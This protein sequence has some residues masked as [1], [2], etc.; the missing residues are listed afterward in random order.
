MRPP[1]DLIKGE[2]EYEVKAILSHQG[3][4]RNRSYLVRWKGYSSADDSWEP[5]THLVH[6]AD[7]LAAYKRCHPKTFSP[8]TTTSTVSIN[9]I[10][11][12][13]PAT[14][15]TP[16]ARHLRQPTHEQVLWTHKLFLDD[17]LHASPLFLAL[18]P[19]SPLY[20]VYRAALQ[21]FQVENV[22]KYLDESEPNLHLTK[23]ILKTI[24]MEL[25]PDLMQ[26]FNQLGGADLIYNIR[27]AHTNPTTRPSGGESASSSDLSAP[28]PVCVHAP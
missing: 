2:E 20:L 19:D 18:D 25:V 11:L 22:A 23:T 21:S 6:A 1:P 26:L 14:H 12:D 13:M 24:A 15:T 5:E 7:L 8:R 17:S 4:T 16:F 28:L 9:R 3:S 10:S 27:N